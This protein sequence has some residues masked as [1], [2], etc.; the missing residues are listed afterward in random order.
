VLRDEEG[1]PPTLVP[2]V[3]PLL[4]W[5]PVAEDAV[6]ALRKIAEERVGE[7]IDALLDPNQPFAVRRRLA[8]VFSICVSQRA[9]DGLLL[10]LEDL[11]FEVRFQCGRSL[12]S[13]LEKNPRIRIDRERVFDVVRKEVASAVRCGRAIACSTT[14]IPSSDRSWTSF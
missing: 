13:V 6:R 14:S 4:A 1:L 12:S 9:V 3:I 10:G 8:R 7:L 2:H 11:R 5:D